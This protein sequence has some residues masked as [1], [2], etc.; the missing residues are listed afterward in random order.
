MSG[1]R[2]G[3]IK[4]GIRLGMLSRGAGTERSAL[5]IT[6]VEPRRRGRGRVG[7]E[8]CGVKVVSSGRSLGSDGEIKCVE[9]G[10]NWE[11]SVNYH[12]LRWRLDLEAK[13][14]MDRTLARSAKR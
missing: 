3:E 9:I 6:A 7:G 12:V 4:C 1:K 11:I 8:V 2:R 10:G 5:R 13:Q 14:D